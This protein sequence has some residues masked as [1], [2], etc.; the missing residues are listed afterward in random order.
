MKNQVKN[1]NRKN[2]KCDICDGELDMHFGLWCPRCDKPIPYQADIYDFFKV[3]RYIAAQ[4]ELEKD[5]EQKILANTEYPGNDSY[6]EWY[7]GNTDVYDYG[8]NTDCM[9]QFDH[10]LMK[11]FGFVEGDTLIFHFSW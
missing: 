2:P 10:G 4:E 11:H 3:A 5:W 8:P 9:V 1:K 7:I 6:I